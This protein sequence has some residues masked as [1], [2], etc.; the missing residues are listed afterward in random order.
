[1]TLTKQ[2]DNDYNDIV[3]VIEDKNISTQLC[4]G[5]HA[6]NT[7][8]LEKFAILSMFLLVLEFTE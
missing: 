5:T 7:L 1:M 4:G 3:R 2:G 6:F 8:F